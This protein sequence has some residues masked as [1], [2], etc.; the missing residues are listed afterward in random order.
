M[1][2]TKLSANDS[3][4]TSDD[5]SVE[6]P[7]TRITIIEE[8]FPWITEEQENTIISIQTLQSSIKH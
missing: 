5:S 2:K 3:L 6:L 7:N 8:H 4:C 1:K